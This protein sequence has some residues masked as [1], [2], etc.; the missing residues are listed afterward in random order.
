MM[1]N[2]LTIFILFK[3]DKTLTLMPAL[4][5]YSASIVSFLAFGFFFKSE[6][7]IDCSSLKTVP[8]LV[9]ATPCLMVFAIAL[10]SS[11][12][13]IN[14]M[15]SYVRRK[16]SCCVTFYPP[17]TT[18]AACSPTRPY[19]LSNVASRVDTARGRGRRPA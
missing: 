12:S 18:A 19:G 16:I 6:M 3:L 7:V 5:S 2:I 17:P 9:K 4:K 14:A 8:A 10:V 11:H 15:D 1:V 13:K